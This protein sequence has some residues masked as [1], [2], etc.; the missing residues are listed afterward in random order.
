MQKQKPRRPVAA[1]RPRL[2]VKAWLLELQ[3]RHDRIADIKAKCRP[4]K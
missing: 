2:T 1:S 4:A 3:A